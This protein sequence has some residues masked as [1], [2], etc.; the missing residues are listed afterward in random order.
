MMA[1]RGKHSAAAGGPARHIPVM[2]SEVL[3]ALD[4][5]DGDIVVDGTFGAGGYSQAILDQA[6]CK[7]IAID[8][9]PEAFRLSGQLAE[10]YPG[11]L[12]AVLGRYSE[13]EEIAASEGFTAV[14]GVTLDL[15]VSSMQLDEPSRGFS[16]MQ[17]GPLDM[18]MG[19]RGPAASDIVNALAEQELAEIIGKLEIGRAHV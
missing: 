15:G 5:E 2:L 8:R 11:R 12:M 18:R 6:D 4:P 14:D 17:E 16:F 3:V 19:Q 9:D 7:I 1:G 10:A 13:M